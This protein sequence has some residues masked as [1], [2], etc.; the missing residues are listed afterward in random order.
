MTVAA[1]DFFARYQRGMFE[2]ELRDLHPPHTRLTRHF[3]PLAVKI[4]QGRGGKSFHY[5]PWP[6]GQRRFS[7]VFGSAWSY[8]IREQTCEAV[9]EWVRVRPED[10]AQGKF[11]S[12][13]PVEE[14]VAPDGTVY[15][16]RK[17]YLAST[18][19]SISYEWEDR[20]GRWHTT[21]R[22]GSDA[23]FSLDPGDARKSSA[24]GALVKAA[25]LHGVGFELQD[26]KWRDLYTWGKQDLR[27]LSY[28]Q[29]KHAVSRNLRAYLKETDREAPTEREAAVEA[30]EEYAAFLGEPWPSNN[31]ADDSEFLRRL[32]FAERALR[33]RGTR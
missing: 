32:I 6:E 33:L 12:E 18:V 15:R 11:D 26:E 10:V 27:I 9:S 20:E 2:D 19:A 14:R 5:L 16:E 30:L 28:E 17:G 3:D 1:E 4:R 24:S 8:I 21:T 13:L 23:A 25:S 22:D 29:L 31:V 7:D